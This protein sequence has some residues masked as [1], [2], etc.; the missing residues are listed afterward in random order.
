ME[1]DAEIARILADESLAEAVSNWTPETI[2]AEL[3]KY[4]RTGPSFDL[5]M[6]QLSNCL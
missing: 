4:Y 1:I 5:L 2:E 6:T 3:Q